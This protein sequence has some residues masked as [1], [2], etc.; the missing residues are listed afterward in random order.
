MHSDQLVLILASMSVTA[1]SI[2]NL[3]AKTGLPLMNQV[4]GWV[5][6]GTRIS[7][8]IADRFFFLLSSGAMLTRPSV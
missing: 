1:S 2:R 5:V 8:P 4:L 7:V 6:L 3:Q